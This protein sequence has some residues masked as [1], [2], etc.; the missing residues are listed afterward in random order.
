MTAEKIFNWGKQLAKDG[1]YKMQATEVT[2]EENKFEQAEIK[3]ELEYSNEETGYKDTVTLTR[4]G[5]FYADMIEH[6]CY[7]WDCK[8][9]PTSPEEYRE[10]L[11]KRPFTAQLKVDAF[12]AARWYL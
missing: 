3:L 11:L 1:V 9:L 4:S 5:K 6:H 2:F 12:G 7:Q 8:K 10:M